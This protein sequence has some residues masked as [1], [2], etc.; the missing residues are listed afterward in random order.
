MHGIIVG[1]LEVER[2]GEGVETWGECECVSVGRR[3]CE[4]VCGNEGEQK[5]G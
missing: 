2:E 4:C 1:K 3:V 5:E